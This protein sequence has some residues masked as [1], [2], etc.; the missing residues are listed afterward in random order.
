MKHKI[1]KNT[2]ITQTQK[3]KARFSRLLLHPAW[4]WRGPVLILALLKFDTY[5]LT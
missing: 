2:K 1:P 3:I 5:L 4:K